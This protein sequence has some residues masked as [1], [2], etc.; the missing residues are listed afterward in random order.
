MMIVVVMLSGSVHWLLQRYLYLLPIYLVLWRR[1]PLF[2]RIL[3]LICFC[4]ECI[5]LSYSP[6]QI[7]DDRLKMLGIRLLLLS[8]EE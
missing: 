4:F 1:F 7:Y 3:C 2:L 8:L 6:M 5:S